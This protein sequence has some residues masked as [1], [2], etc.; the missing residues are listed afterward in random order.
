MV[1]V[2]TNR[3]YKRTPETKPRHRMKSRGLRARA[4]WMLRKHRSLTMEMLLTALGDTQQKDAESNLRKY[5]SVLVKVGILTIEA[6]R[7]PGKALTSNGFKK[8]VMVI[9]CGREAPLYRVKLGHVY[10]PTT[11]SIYPLN[12][13]AKQEV[14]HDE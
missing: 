12:V 5:L 11:G 1:D 10:A 8:Y 9:D 13:A 14:T 7:V 4:W 3:Q 2:T 6:R